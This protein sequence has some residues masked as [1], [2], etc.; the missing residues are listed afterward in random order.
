M[1]TP[2]ELIFVGNCQKIIDN[3]NT[4]NMSIIKKE[5]IKVKEETIKF[6]Y[7]SQEWGYYPITF[8]CKDN[9]KGP[10]GNFIA[11]DFFGSY[12][13]MRKIL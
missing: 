1:S 10:N 5:D 2:T 11:G 7:A 9:I 3:F 4:C 13:Y 6:K 8:E 12:G